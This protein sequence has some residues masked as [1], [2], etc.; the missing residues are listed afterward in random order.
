[1][2]KGLLDPTPA[3][4]VTI[5]TKGWLRRCKEPQEASD[6]PE[7]QQELDYRVPRKSSTSPSWLN[8]DMT[9]VA[10]ASGLL[11]SYDAR[12]MRCYPVSTRVNSVVNDDEL[13]SAPVELAQVQDRLSPKDGFSESFSAWPAESPCAQGVTTRVATKKA[14]G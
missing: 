13:C 3:A 5:V 1:M 10:A 14:G 6:F 9:D 4:T 7:P 8:P 2:R 12:L 11:K